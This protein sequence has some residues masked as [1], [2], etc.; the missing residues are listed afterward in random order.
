MKVVKILQNDD[1]NQEVPEKQSGLIRLKKF[2]LIIMLLIVVILSVGVTA[3]VFLFGG[4]KTVDNGGSGR[5]EFNKLFAAYDSLKSSYFQEIDQDKLINGAINGM[6]D[7]LEDPYSDYMTV[8]EASNFHQSI[9]SSFEGIGA[10]IQEKD[11]FIMI[12]SPL[13]GS[14]AEKAGL[15]PNDKV[16]EVDGESIQGMSSTEA[17]LLIRGEKGTEVKLTIERHG[18]DETM[19]VPIIRDTIPIE[20]VYGELL[21]DGI[22]KVQIT[23][24]SDNTTNELVAVLNELQGQGMKGLILDL[25]QNPGGLLE[26]AVEISSMFVPEGEIIFQIEDRNGNRV[27]KKAIGSKNP[28]VPLVVVIDKGSASA[29]EILAGA[30]SESAD[31]PLIGEKSFGKGTVQRAQDF[32]DGSNIKFTTEKWLTPKGNWIH[33]KGI[34]PDYEVSLPEYATLPFIN[35]DLEIKLSSSSNQVKAVQ[36][37]LVALGYD[38]GREDG[39]FDEKSKQAVEAFQ[40][41]EKLEVTGVLTGES[42]LVLMEKLREKLDKDDTQIKKA[43]EVLKGIINE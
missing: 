12:V 23:S 4:E 1:L 19:V 36:Q 20:T 9:S 17:V 32:S 40:S 28:E 34:V 16:L 25:R 15:R 29:S 41:A 27:E 42:T 39:F 24:F 2:Q 13:K 7:A 6:V 10:E 8:D 3:V 18:M 37:M 14:P 21:E 11:G 26:R 35:P 33:Q 43:V 38:P 31:I 30:V 5:S 22:A